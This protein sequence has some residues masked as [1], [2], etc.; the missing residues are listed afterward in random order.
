MLRIHHHVT[1]VSSCGLVSCR[2]SE[3]NASINSGASKARLRRPTLTCESTPAATSRSIP[4]LVAWNDRPINSAAVDTVN[5][6]AAGSAPN[7]QAG[8]GIATGGSDALS[9]GRLQRAH[10]LLE[11]ACVLHRSPTCRGEESDPTVDP[12]VR[13][14]GVG[15]ADVAGR[16][17]TI[18]IVQRPARQYK[19][20]RR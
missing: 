2:S 3:L 14:G 5:T 17:Q 20:D 6:G 11:L 13:C 19:G 12:P 8:C 16:G 18:D 4:W 15:R 9:P 10:L 7:E 1:S